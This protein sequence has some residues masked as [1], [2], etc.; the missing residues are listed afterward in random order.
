MT[1]FS[2]YIVYVD[3]SGDAT[4]KS[5]NASPLLCLN[6]C[7][8]EKDYYVQTLIPTFNA[9]KFK[10]WGS[11]NIVLHERDL[12][13]PD[14]IRDPAD[15]SKY[16]RLKGERRAAFMSD[17]SALMRSAD[18]LCFCVIIDKGKIPERFKAYDPYHIGL[19]RGF[20]QIEDYL[21]LNDPEELNK[22]LHVVFEKRGH[23]EDKALSTAYQ[24]IVLQGSLLGQ[25]ES[26]GFSN[27]K[28]ELMDKRSNSTGLQIADLTARPIGNHYL[29]ASGQRTNTDQRSVEV[30]MPKLRYCSGSRSKVGEYDVFHESLENLKAGRSLPIDGR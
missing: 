25:L 14:K 23:E 26:Y 21:K 12:R 28:L 7:L 9:L 27:F 4:W 24:Q 30:L 17:L 5:A 13:K 15:R 22:D 11:D 6:Y 29:Q 2:K 16:A 10:Y 1:D 8:F 18:F 19:S 20:R 3:E